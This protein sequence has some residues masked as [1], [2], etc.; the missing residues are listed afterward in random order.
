[1][2]SPA[3]KVSDT[4][5]Y[6]IFTVGVPGL[7]KSSLIN[8]LKTALA[9]TESSCVEVCVSDEVRSAYLAREYKNREMNLERVTQEEIFKVEVECGPQVRAKLNTTIAMKLMNLRDSGSSNCFMILDKNHCTQALI[10]FI[11]TESES[12]FKGCQIHKKLILPNQFIPGQRDYFGPFIFDTL[13]IGLIRSLNRKEHLT[14]KYG[15]LHSL[16]SFFTC[17]RSHVGDE[18]QAKFPLATYKHVKVDYYN[19]TTANDFKSESLNSDTLE[20]LKSLVTAVADK[21][22]TIEQAADSI[23]RLVEQLVPMSAFVELTQ[24]RV[25]NLV[26]LIIKT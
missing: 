13:V 4:Q 19:E 26:N 1:M 8:K 9:A 16:L 20:K 3:T 17:L 7:G 21:S 14:M 15:S 12:I 22:T 5:L 25:G 18:F 6:L 2:E 24:D 10:D 23:P 11:S